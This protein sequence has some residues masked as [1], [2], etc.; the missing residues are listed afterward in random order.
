MYVYEE[1][2]FFIETEEEYLKYKDLADINILSHLKSNALFKAN[3]HKSIWLLKHGININ[4]VDKDG[5]NA[6]LY[7]LLYIKQSKRKIKLLIEH[8]INVNQENNMGKNAL[9][10][11]KSLDCANL[12]LNA[13][14]DLNIFRK[15]Q[16]RLQ[17]IENDEIR[18]IVTLRI[19]EE[20]RHSISSIISHDK[21][22]IAKS[23]LRRL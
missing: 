6:L 13:G 18:K 15:D 2:I 5:N 20:D 7:T 4:Q 10:I 21:K 12:I 19:I 23:T 8:D 11:C 14:F 22:P 17:N 16:N 3:H 9:T 1:Q